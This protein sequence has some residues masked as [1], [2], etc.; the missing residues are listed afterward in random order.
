MP[1][2]FV[3]G[4]WNA[5]NISLLEILHCK[6]QTATYTDTIPTGISK[7][8]VTDPNATFKNSIT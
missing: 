7:A 4:G 2:L 5:I 1:Q 8:K 3:W 6:L